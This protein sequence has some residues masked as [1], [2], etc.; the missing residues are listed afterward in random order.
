[1]IAWGD[2]RAQLVDPTLLIY[3]VWG[4]RPDDIPESY[5]ETFNV[6][7][8]PIYY[9]R[10]SKLPPILWQIGVNDDFFSYHGIN[11]TFEAAKNQTNKWLH[12]QPNGHHGLVGHEDTAK[13][14]VDYIISGG[15]S[16]PN[17]TYE[18]IE[19]EFGLVPCLLRCLLGPVLLWSARRE[20]EKLARGHV[21]E[22]R[23][24]IKR[25]NW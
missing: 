2:F 21:Y 12:I 24:F 4:I 9:L 17:I 19:K 7:F 8:D 18:P 5:W 23:M 1:M 15:T 22:P 11:G 14:F 10:S 16:P 25:K 6:N 20:E 13:Y 3:W